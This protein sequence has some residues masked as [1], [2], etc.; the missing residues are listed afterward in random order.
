M[1]K[2]STRFLL[3]YPHHPCPANRS[4]AQRLAHSKVLEVMIILF[5]QLFRV[6]PVPYVLFGIDIEALGV[7]RKSNRWDDGTSVFPVVDSVPVDALEEGMRFDTRCATL[8]V[9]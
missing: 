9:S 2:I 1:M 4:V 7:A 6:L 5:P 3:Q 8:N